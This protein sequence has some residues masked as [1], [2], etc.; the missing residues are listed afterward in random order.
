MRPSQFID[1]DFG[2]LLRLTQVVN[3][4][5]EL[6]EVSAVYKFG[7]RFHEHLGEE[8]GLVLGKG[9]DESAADFGYK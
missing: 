2:P 1:V 3:Y 4:L 8:V 6:V 7:V 5:G 9:A